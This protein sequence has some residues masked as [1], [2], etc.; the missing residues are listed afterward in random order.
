[1]NNSTGHYASTIDQLKLAVNYLKQFNIF[2]KDFS[3]KDYKNN[4]IPLDKI[5]T[6]GLL[7]QYKE[8]P[9]L[10]DMLDSQDLY[11]SEELELLGVLDLLQDF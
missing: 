1:M 2:V 11:N 7:A 9:E 3:I 4:N 6:E 5:N 8:L 10:M